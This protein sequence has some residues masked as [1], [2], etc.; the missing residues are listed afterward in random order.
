MMNKVTERDKERRIHYQIQV[1]PGTTRLI[2]EF[3]DSQ[4]EVLRQFI[5]LLIRMDKKPD[6]GQ[7]KGSHVAGDLM[8][9]ATTPYN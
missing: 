8:A 3:D 1:R 6:E 5:D 9:L 7:N 2:A 4:A